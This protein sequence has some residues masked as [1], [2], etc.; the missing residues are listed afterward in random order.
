MCAL[1]FAPATTLLAQGSLT[2]PGPPAATMKTLDQVEARF[3]INT[4]NAPGNAANQFIIS[5]AGSYYLTGNLVGVSGKNGILINA[6]NVTID[7]NGFMLNGISGSLAAITDGGANHGNATVRNGSIAGWGGAGIDLSSSFN[8]IVEN[9][10]VTDNGGV[11]MKMSDAC[12]LRNCVA[13]NNASDNID[14]GFNANLNH[15]ISV[16]S[17]TGYGINVGPDSAITDCAANFNKSYGIL[18]GGNSTV[19]HCS[20]GQNFSAGISVGSGSTVTGCSAS[21]NGQSPGT[22]FAIFAQNGCTVSDCNASYNTVQYGL[23]ANPGSTVT[24]CTATGNTSA[25]TISS[26]IL[27]AGCTVI[28]CT[29]SSNANTNATA[30]HTTGMGIY[31][32]GSNT[33]IKDSTCDNNKGDGINVITDCVV[34]ENHCNSN[35]ADGIFSSG[36]GVCRIDGNHANFN[37]GIGIHSS[38]DWVIRN[39]SGSNGGGNYVPTS[40]PDIAP[41]QTAS[42]ATNPYANLQ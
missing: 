15:C 38:F 6:P 31:V 17:A 2:P 28:A 21:G 12:V 32:N 11:G 9:L 5:A 30:S 3:I 41:I 36:G 18:A 1:L 19:S 7:L 37:S 27:A 26:G 16:G 8:S 33:T 22:T 20:A 25:Q 42:T 23:V 13:R 40:G 29:A 39:T 34:T 24:H 35:G 10:I 4:A 14:T